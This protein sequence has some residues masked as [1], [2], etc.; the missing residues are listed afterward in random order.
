MPVKRELLAFLSTEHRIMSQL[1]AKSTKF[2]HRQSIEGLPLKGVILAS[3]LIP[4][5]NG[6]YTKELTTSIKNSVPFL[7][8]LSCVLKS[9]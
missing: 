1:V 3:Y 7:S 4:Q 2:R 9:T 8:V 6:F 5:Y